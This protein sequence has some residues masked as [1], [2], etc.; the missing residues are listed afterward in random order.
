MLSTTFYF[1]SGFF[2]ASP[3][4]YLLTEYICSSPSG[5]VASEKKWELIW[6]TSVVSFRNLFFS[7]LM[8]AHQQYL[9]CNLV[10]WPAEGLFLVLFFHRFLLDFWNALLFCT[11]QP[12]LNLHGHSMFLASPRKLVTFIDHQSSWDSGGMHTFLRTHSLYLDEILDIS[13]L[14]IDWFECCG[15]N[16]LMKGT[17][18]WSKSRSSHYILGGLLLQYHMF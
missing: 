2:L 4:T 6:R 7:W 11:E 5:K 1:L 9:N 15:E 16:E 8:S 14:W 17:V 12:S 3:S 10:N 13:D 18:G